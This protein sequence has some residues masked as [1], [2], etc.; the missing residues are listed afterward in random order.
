[1]SLGAITQTQIRL[2]CAGGACHWVQNTPFCTTAAERRA[3]EAGVD[4]LIVVADL[5]AYDEYDEHGDTLA[6]AIRNVQRLVEAMD[7]SMPI[8]LFLNK[9][10]ALQAKLEIPGGGD[11]FERA[12]PTFG[13]IEV[14]RMR[15]EPGTPQYYEACV[16]H[17]KARFRQA[18]PA[19]R[20][21]LQHVACAT[22]VTG[23]RFFWHAVVN[24]VMETVLTNQLLQGFNIG[25][26]SRE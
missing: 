18:V 19:E 8:V 16:N 11:A 14:R 1:M 6:D 20:L 26:A 17:V 24:S 7:E 12:F 4:A 3:V 21:L 9:H 5:S 2:G 10:D 23:M 13:G 15:G 22:D 25:T